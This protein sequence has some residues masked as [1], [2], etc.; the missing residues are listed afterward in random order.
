MDARELAQAYAGVKNRVKPDKISQS[1][2]IVKTARDKDWH[3]LTKKEIIRASLNDIE[4]ML[5]NGFTFDDISIV[6]WNKGV[7]IDSSHIRQSYHYF[8]RRMLPCVKSVKPPKGDGKF[9]K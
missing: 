7:S 5:N 8:K 2:R 6:F 3:G 4:D 9:H 1:K